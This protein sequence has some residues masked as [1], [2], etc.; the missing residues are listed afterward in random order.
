MTALVPIV[1]SLA[2]AQAAPAEEAPRKP[3]ITIQ[4]AT[5]PGVKVF[6]LNA[7]W[8]PNTFAAMEKPGEGFYNKRTWPFARL[9]TTRAISIAGT[10]VPAGNYAIVFVP[11]TADDKGMSV[12]L[13]KLTVP[14]FLQPGN[15]MTPT[16]EGP[17]VWQEPARFERTETTEPALKIDLA[18]HMAGTKLVVRYGDRRLVRDLAY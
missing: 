14:E 11:N 2:L 3:A 12:E 17:T 1:I 8:G 5:A 10:S 18:P 16:P 6:Y 15:V 13:R 7:P 4:S 9:E